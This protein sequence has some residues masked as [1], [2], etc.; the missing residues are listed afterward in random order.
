V[1]AVFQHRIEAQVVS[2]QKHLKHT[3]TLGDQVRDSL[4][5]LRIVRGDNVIQKQEGELAIEQA[6]GTDETVIYTAESGDT[7]F[8]GTIAASGSTHKL[9][10]IFATNHSITNSIFPGDT[11][12]VYIGTANVAGG[13]WYESGIVTE[14]DTT[15]NTVTIEGEGLSHIPGAGA[16]IY[17]VSQEDQI[18]GGNNIVDKRFR[19][20]VSLT[21]GEMYVTYVPKGNFVE[22]ISPNY[23]DGQSA[24][25]MP[26][27]FSAIG[28]PQTTTANPTIKQVVVAEHS[29][30]RRVLTS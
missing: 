23:Q 25:L 26:I 28:T 4:F 5:V 30:I 16:T 27:A 10:S 8:S 19:T 14:R 13:Q 15:N 7:A 12:A 1:E 11:V 24:I 17:K 9:F 29:I 22:G 2:S 21:N 20:V 6:T 18:I 3:Q